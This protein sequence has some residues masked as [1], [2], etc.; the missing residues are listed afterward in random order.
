MAT[1][2]QKDAHIS[3]ASTVVPPLGVATARWEQRLQ[4]AV[5]LLAR[6][7]LGLLFLTQLSW[8][9]PPTFGC[10]ADFAFTSANADGSLKRTRGLCDWIGVESVYAN[11]DRPVL[12][13]NIRP[14]AQLNGVFIDNVVKPNIRWFGY[15][16][17]GSEALIATTMFLGLFSR[18]GA[19]V[20]I[21][22]SAQ[23]LVGLAGIPN[24]FEWEWSYILMLLLSIVVFGL[25]PGRILGLDTLLRPRLAAAGAHGNRLAR[26]ALLLT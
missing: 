6:L 2:P 20:A 24:P 25:V 3:G 15:L 21:G 12:G 23:L 5:M 17:F 19:L 14:L 13:I 4:R 26:A 1:I 18:L 22:M 9:M 16:I 10:G 11:R 7:G 8:K